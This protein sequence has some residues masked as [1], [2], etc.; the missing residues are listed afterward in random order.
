MENSSY[1]SDP[2]WL[3]A[4]DALGTERAEDEPADDTLIRTVA[5]IFEMYRIETGETGAAA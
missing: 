3:A 5:A 1:E 4:R 2:R